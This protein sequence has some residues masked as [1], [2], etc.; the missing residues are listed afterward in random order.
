MNNN[1][2]DY[3][4]MIPCEFCENLINFTEYSTH[5]LECM[6]NIQSR[7]INFNTLFESNNNNISSRNTTRNRIRNIIRSRIS[8]NNQN[9]N[10]QE[11]NNSSDNSD[12]LEENNNSDNLEENNN[13]DNLEENN[14]SDNLEENNNSDNLEENN[15]RNETEQF[16]SYIDNFINT[17]AN[18][19]TT[20]NV[21]GFDN[22]YGLFENLNNNM[23]IDDDDD[24]NDIELDN[25]NLNDIELENY[26]LNDIE[27]DNYNLN[28]IELDN[29][30]LNDNNLN[31]N[32][33]NDNNLNDNNLNDNNLNNNN[34]NN[35]DNNDNNILNNFLDE[36]AIIDF[37]RYNALYTSLQNRININRRN[38]LR[39]RLTRML[40]NND[41]ANRYILRNLQMFDVVFTS[42]DRDT[43]ITYN[44]DFD[45][46][47]KNKFNKKSLVKK[48][49]NNKEF[50]NQCTICFCSTD[51]IKDLKKNYFLQLNCNHYYCK[52]CITKWFKKNP[53][54]PL[55]KKDYSSFDQNTNN[56]SMNSQMGSL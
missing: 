29:Y 38:N 11:N 47:I 40:N 23:L 16:L 20:S 19:S 3:N 50:E 7:V 27:L 52:E 17:I 1:N 51:D 43:N 39:E 15:N 6:N 31:D 26:N 22:N 34:D 14:N 21:R 9:I 12:N 53:Q 32:N 18:N 2:D 8:T 49:L 13:S 35:N 44:L 42:L 28:D 54:C 45:K 24:D 48:L 30:N 33:L 10:N 41:I 36:N 37:N 5:S 25:Y 4:D 46:I 56:I 55:C